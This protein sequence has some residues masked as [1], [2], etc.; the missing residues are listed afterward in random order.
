MKNKKYTNMKIIHYIRTMMVA[1]TCLLCMAAHADTWDGTTIATAYAGG[2]GTQADPYQINTCSQLA[3][4]AQQVNAGTSYSGIYFKQTDDLNLNSKAWTPIGGTTGADV[5]TTPTFKGNYDGQSKA[6]NNLTVSGT[7]YTR[8]S[9]LFGLAGNATFKNMIL[10]GVNINTNI[11]AGGII[12]YTYGGVTIDN[13]HILCGTVTSTAESAGGMVG[14]LNNTTTSGNISSITKCTNGANING[15][16]GNYEGIGGMVGY[17]TYGTLTISNCANVGKITKGSGASGGIMGCTQ[18]MT[19]NIS[20]CLNAGIV[21]QG[22]IQGWAQA[23]STLTISKCLNVAQASNGGIIHASTSSTVT[24]TNNYYDKQMCIKGGS[25]G[26]DVAGQAEGKLT[27]ELLG[28]VFTSFGTDWTTTSGL[29]P[30]PA[31]LTADDVVKVAIAPISLYGTSSTYE[32]YNTISTNFSSATTSLGSTVNW[33]HSNTTAMTLSG[34]N[35]SILAAGTDNL[36]CELNCTQKLITTT[37]IPIEVWTAANWTSLYTAF[38]NGGGDYTYKTS[39]TGTDVTV[40]IHQYALN[41]NI[42][43]RSDIDFQSATLTPLGNASNT[44]QGNLYGHQHKLSNFNISTTASNAPGGLIGQTANSYIDNLNICGATVTV[45]NNVYAGALV[46]HL[47]QSTVSSC[48]VSAIVT[49]TFANGGRAGLITGNCNLASSIIQCA[50][51]GTVTSTDAAGGITGAMMSTGH[52]SQCVSSANVSV[53]NSNANGAG[54]IIGFSMS[55][56]ASNCLALGHIT[57]TMS[58]NYGAILG[59]KLSGTITLSNNYYDKQMCTAGA[60]SN[61]DAGGVTGKL[62]SELTGTQIFDDTNWTRT[63]GLYPVPKNVST[64]D[65]AKVVAAP[66]SL[67]NSETVASVGNGFLFAATSLS[68]A[69]VTWAKTGSNIAIYTKGGNP[70]AVGDDAL[71]ATSGCAFKNIPLTAK[72]EARI[73]VW[74]AKQWTDLTP[75]INNGGEVIYQYTQYPGGTAGD[76]KYVY[77]EK[78]LKGQTMYA[79]ADVDFQ[80]ATIVPMCQTSGTSDLEGTF[81]GNNHTF[82][83]FVINSTNADGVGLFGVAGGGAKIQNFNI[84]GAEITGKPSGS[85]G[86]TASI[87]GSTSAG[88]LTVTNTTSFAIVSGSNWVGGLVG[89]CFFGTCN[90]SNSAMTGKVTGIRYIGGIVGPANTTVNINNCFCGALVKGSDASTGNVGGIMALPTTACSVTNCLFVGQTVAKTTGAISGANKGTFTNNYYDKQMCVSGGIAGSDV[91]GATGKLTTEL[92]GSTGQTLL[93][94]GWTNIDAGA[95]P[96]PDAIKTT[97]VALTLA[98]PLK[99]TNEETTEGISSAYT[100]ATAVNGNAATWTSTNNTTLPF[101]GTGSGTPNGSG[102]G[103]LSVSVGGCPIKYISVPAYA[104]IEVWNAT[105]WT[106]L[107]TVVNTGAKGTYAYTPTTGEF[108]GI[109]QTA[110]VKPKVSGQTIYVM[111]DVAFDPAT[112]I[113]P[114]AEMDGTLEGNNHT[115]SNFKINTTASAN[116]VG[117]IRTTNNATVIQDLNVCGA[118]ITGSSNY[119][120]GTLVGFASGGTLK[121]DKTSVSAIVDGSSAAVGGIV[122]VAMSAACTVSNSVFTGKVTGS[123]TSVGGIFGLS[124]PTFNIDNCSCSALLNGTKYI[125]GI[126]GATINNGG[127]ISNCFFVGQTVGGTS[128][129]GIL[130]YGSDMTKVTLTNNFYDRQMCNAGGIAGSDVTGATGLLTNKLTGTALQ[131]LLGTNWTYT[132]GYYPIP[133]AVKDAKATQL[134]SVPVQQFVTSDGMKDAWTGY[135]ANDGSDRPYYKYQTTN[136]FK[137]PA[138]LLS[139]TADGSDIEGWNTNDA[140]ALAINAGTSTPDGNKY[141]VSPIRTATDVKDTLAATLGCATRYL[142]LTVPALT[143]VTDGNT[144][145]TMPTTDVTIWH[146]GQITASAPTVAAGKEITYKRI[147]ALQDKNG[148]AGN[149]TATL[150]MP[151]DVQAITADDYNDMVTYVLRP[152]SK[153]NNT[154]GHFSMWYLKSIDGQNDKTSDAGFRNGRWYDDFTFNT[155]GSIAT[156][157]GGTAFSW[158]T[159]PLHLAFSTSYFENRPVEFHYINSATTA[160]TIPGAFSDKTFT[161]GATRYYYFYGNHTMQNHQVT[162]NANNK[163]YAYLLNPMTGFFELYSKTATIPAFEAYIQSTDNASTRL[164]FAFGND[165]GTTEIN[166]IDANGNSFNAWNDNGRLTVT[167]S[168]AQTVTIYN[169]HGAAVASWTLTEGETKRISLPHAVYIVKGNESNTTVK[170]SL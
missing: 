55:G 26:T 17:A 8:G 74:N 118:S 23:G 146:G 85:Y 102:E 134:S 99:L 116:G 68:N 98:A 72:A 151:F 34:G 162:A 61:A 92:L 79:M 117:L 10:S 167:T 42:N 83:N 138:L 148:V 50:V 143:E 25:N 105:D 5:A 40:K 14:Y 18:Y 31:A 46:G 126:L 15:T 29:Y 41:Q 157:N 119:G 111:D 47:G 145:A 76:T 154:T 141:L 91:T 49:N 156:Y 100:Y 64:T 57:G 153:M 52:I 150:A 62:T 48:S 158:T 37:Y 124:L 135:T 109:T 12:G 2:T 139:K 4:L 147:F 101:D 43:I 32:N 131:S 103:N 63:N 77:I 168:A 89:M 128:M 163:A 75:I 3:Y 144:L 129:G 110:M 159:V 160:Y 137:R 161:G 123:G 24:L 121:I 56:T 33:A 58:T 36:I 39:G 67:S 106:N 170:V 13:C 142:L 122:G 165:S 66:L 84:C 97:N 87:V 71:T 136:A 166:A 60:V 108:A 120:V 28:T 20:N 133:T 115:L 104:K 1:L 70:V 164:A 80:A 7:T 169:V 155:D 132:D 9:G 69:T 22:G 93:G 127:T 95:Y 96:V 45:S 90:V 6:I 53:T 44:F 38:N 113:N 30:Y 130:G 112:A 65:A 59:N 114:M 125:G 140:T 11:W 86:G 54:G 73:E 19:I 88:G 107:T 27:S 78:Q 51:T 152:K 81:E 82:S 21:N 149:N 16:G 94:S 35:A